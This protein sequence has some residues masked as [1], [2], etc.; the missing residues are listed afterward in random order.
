MTAHLPQHPESWSCPSI[1]I[2]SCGPLDLEPLPPGYPDMSLLY[3][4]ISRTIS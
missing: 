2:L 1:S 4:R 3:L